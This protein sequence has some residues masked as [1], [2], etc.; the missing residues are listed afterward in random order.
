[1]SEKCSK[2]EALFLFSSE[3]QLLEHVKNCA[4]C[5]EEH[6]KMQKTRSLVQEVKS[7]Y[8]ET[9]KKSVKKNVLKVAATMTVLFLAYFSFTYGFFTEEY[10]VNSKIA[11]MEAE[12]FTSEIGL[13]T[14][15]YGL[16]VV[17]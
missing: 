11:A 8:L 5:K 12:A 7:H 1:M 17:Y 10:D 15:E 16:F 6:E 3:E 4:D 13:P 14:D 9:S 2:Y